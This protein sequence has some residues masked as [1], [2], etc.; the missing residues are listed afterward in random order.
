[1]AVRAGHLNPEF[2]HQ[3]LNQQLAP[4]T[5]FLL[6]QLVHQVELLE[7]QQHQLQQAMAWAGS[8]PSGNMQSW[9]MQFTRQFNIQ[10]TIQSNIEKHKQQI[11]ILQSQ[12]TA[13]QAQ[14]LMHLQ[15]VL[16][17]GGARDDLSLNMGRM[18]ISG[19]SKLL[20][21]INQNKSA[22]GAKNMNASSPNL[23]LLPSSPWSRPDQFRQQQ[24]FDQ[25][26][27]LSRRFSTGSWPDPGSNVVKT[28]YNADNT[29]PY[30]DNNV[31]NTSASTDEIKTDTLGIVEFKPG[32]QWR[33][34]AQMKEPMEDPTMTPGSMAFRAAFRLG[35][36]GGRGEVRR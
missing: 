24:Q 23:S 2:G 18:S 20:R 33:G 10:S 29:R 6:T 4:Q 26:Q 1:M 28:W 35:E 16:L 5:V 13:Q 15:S 8:L 19:G 14:Y 3:I 9:H 25:H 12:I 27:P 34:T 7:H 11:Q 30:S 17:S 36:D 21:I 32:Q 31:V 22:P